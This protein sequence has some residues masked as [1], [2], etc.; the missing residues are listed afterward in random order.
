MVRGVTQNIGQTAAHTEQRVAWHQLE[1]QTITASKRLKRS[2]EVVLAGQLPTDCQHSHS[3]TSRHQV[4][5]TGHQAGVCQRQAEHESVQTYPFSTAVWTAQ[6]VQIC[7]IHGVDL[8]GTIR[9]SPPHTHQMPS[10]GWYRPSSIADTPQAYP[11]F[12]LM[13]P[14]LDPNSRACRESA[15]PS[16]SSL[17]R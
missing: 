12:V 4:C 17:S 3:T 14:P 16:P 2:A 6:A 13:L 7:T 10:W 8:C 11:V 5:P 1:V 15:S 9:S